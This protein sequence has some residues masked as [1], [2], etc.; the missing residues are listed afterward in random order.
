MTAPDVT[1]SRGRNDRADRHERVDISEEI[2]YARVWATPRRSLFG[3]RPLPQNKI[4]RQFVPGAH[5]TNQSAYFMSALSTELS[6][7]FGDGLNG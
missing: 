1:T 6:P 4:A 7:I 3:R 2:Q 5:L